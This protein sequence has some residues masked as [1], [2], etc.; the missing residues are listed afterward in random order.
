MERRQDN[1]NPVYSPPGEWN[2]FGT[3]GCYFVQYETRRRDRPQ[4]RITGGATALGSPVARTRCSA[5][6]STLIGDL[7]GS[8]EAERPG[9]LVDN[10]P[11]SSYSSQ[12]YFN[13]MRF[14]DD[15]TGIAGP[16]YR[17]MHSR[18]IGTLRNP[19]LPSAGARLGH[20]ADLLP[21][22][23]PGHQQ[24]R[25]FAAAGQSAE[26]DRLGTSQRRD[27]AVQHLPQPLLPERLLQRRAENA[28][29]PGRSR[30]TC[31]RKLCAPGTSSPIRATA[32]CSAS[33]VP[34]TTTSWSA[35]R[36]DA[37][38]RPRVP[39]PVTPRPRRSRCG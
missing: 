16:C 4:S 29:E 11:A 8:P 1:G 35:C 21:A 13:S 18:F 37:S 2:F 27:G 30:R 6:R 23:G 14:G 33:S 24:R 32:A 3:N 12:I 39:L 19:N 28:E 20:V 36:K 10:N 7:F 25:K 22:E 38:S 9:R 26:D 31:T 5:S 15:Q 17:R 34:G